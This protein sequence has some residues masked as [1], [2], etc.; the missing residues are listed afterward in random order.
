MKSLIS[1]DSLLVLNCKQLFP[2]CDIEEISIE[3][4]P[5]PSN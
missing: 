3:I 2:T 4:E 1:P 5:N